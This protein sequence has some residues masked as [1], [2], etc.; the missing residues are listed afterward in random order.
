VWVAA[1]P[2]LTERL[3][4]AIDASMGHL[5]LAGVV[6]LLVRGLPAAQDGC[7]HGPALFEDADVVLQ[8]GKLG[9]LGGKV[10]ASL[11]EETVTFTFVL[12]PSVH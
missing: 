8:H 3:E 11:S 2:L 6:N 7:E 9:T 4:A 10:S 12:D 1:E 5:C